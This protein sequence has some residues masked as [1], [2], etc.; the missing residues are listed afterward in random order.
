MTA[1]L[2]VEGLV[3][4]FGGLAAVRGVDF[5]VRRGQIKALIGP[6]GAGKTV[7]FNA[8]SGIVQPT[9]GRITLHGKDVTNLPVHERARMGLGRTF[10]VIQLFGQL[11][12]FDNLL[13]ATH[14]H[15]P[16]HLAS[17]IFATDRS[18]RAEIENRERVREVIREMGLEEVAHRRVSDLPFGLLRVTE[19]ARALV[20]DFPLIMLDEAASGLDNTETDRLRDLLLFVRDLGVTL[21]VI[22]HDVRLVTSISDYMYVLDRG[23]LIS[24]GPPERV[25]SDPAV[26]A[27][28]LGGAGEPAGAKAG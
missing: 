1:L 28:Y 7:T 19:I 3:R 4:H 25:K 16:T 10:Q 5:S 20:T 12:V 8:V 24:E 11:T 6:N 21:L 17:N 9:A 26:I 13:V 2:E 18:I 22:E 15:N 27:A 23:M 14:V